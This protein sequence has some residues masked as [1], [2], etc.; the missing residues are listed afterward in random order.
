MIYKYPLKL[1]NFQ[2]LFLPK[3]AVILDVQNQRGQLCLWA[4]VDSN[5]KNLAT[6]PIHIIGTGWE[7]I[8]QS[9]LRYI[10][11]VQMDDCVWHVCEEI[12]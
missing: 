3:R 10:A 6:K 1:Q 2:E 8:P 5:E 7:H 4:M 11:T 9:S 12:C